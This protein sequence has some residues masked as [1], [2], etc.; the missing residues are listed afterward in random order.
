MIENGEPNQRKI[1]LEAAAFFTFFEA[2]GAAE[3]HAIHGVGRVRR[4][5]RDGGGRSSSSRVFWS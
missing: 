3:F 4:G 5:L 1:E 2:K